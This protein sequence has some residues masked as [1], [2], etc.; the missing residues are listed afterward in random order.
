MSYSLTWINLNRKNLT[1]RR[2]NAKKTF[3]INV[4]RSFCMGA[5]IRGYRLHWQPQIWWED[6]TM[7]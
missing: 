7:G 2:E 3:S 5:N 4:K 6:G 1:Q